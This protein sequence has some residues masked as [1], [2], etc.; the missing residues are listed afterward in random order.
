M[1]LQ[2]LDY[3]PVLNRIEEETSDVSTAVSVSHHIYGSELLKESLAQESTA[4]ATEKQKKVV[5]TKDKCRST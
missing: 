4:V 3:M 2:T 5:V 1:D